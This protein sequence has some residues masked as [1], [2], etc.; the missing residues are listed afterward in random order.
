M[1]RYPTRP[2][3]ILA[4]A[5]LALIFLASPHAKA[6]PQGHP[7][8]AAVEYPRA[9]PGLLSQLWSFLST[10]WGE[11]GSG[12]D[13]NGADSPNAASSGDTGSVLEPD[14]RP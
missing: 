11:T 8:H 12:L 13:P 6:L 3:F 7:I 9:S 2:P 5:L 4:L 14:G 10:I 1:P